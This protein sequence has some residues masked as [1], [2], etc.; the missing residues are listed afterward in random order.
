MAV[1]WS[2]S[3]ILVD[4]DQEYGAMS[5]AASAH[6]EEED[7]RNKLRIPYTLKKELLSYIADALLYEY[8]LTYARL[9]AR[10]LNYDALPQLVLLCI[11]FAT[12]GQVK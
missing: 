8:I 9:L 5:P 2:Q 7:V 1:H 4:R 3:C 11:E 6:I 10:Y 12:V